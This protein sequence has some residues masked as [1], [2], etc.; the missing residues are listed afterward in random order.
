MRSGIGP[1]GHLRELGIPVVAD[2][3]G[4]G[5][6]LADHPA[7]S[8]DF[9]YGREVRPVPAFQ[10][11]A[12]LRSEGAGADGPP[13]LQCI[14]GGPFA[15]GGPGVFFL[16]V[17]LLKPRSRGAVRLRSADPSDA[18]CI[19]LGYFREPADLDRLAAGLA[20]IRESAVAAVIAELSGGAELAPGRDIANG[21]RDGLREWIRR[22]AWTYH[23]PVGTCAMGPAPDC[24]SVV[25]AAGAVHGIDGL[26]VADAS[27]MPDIP[28]ANTHIPTVMIAERIAALPVT[29]GTSGAR[30]RLPRQDHPNGGTS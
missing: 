10:V 18:P 30:A 3:P 5:A 23:H 6:N 8:I 24:G 22:Q 28:S 11:A 4:V 13:D 26:S 14:V 15:D 20:R 21:D 25:D 7:V 29:R 16:G 2:L 12:T 17:A 27:V 19:D 9:G 1:A